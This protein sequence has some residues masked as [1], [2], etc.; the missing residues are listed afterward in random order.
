VTDAEANR[1]AAEAEY[2]LVQN[3]A[4]DSL[5]SVLTNPLIQGLK[6]EVSRLEVRHAY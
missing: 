5:P 6:Q 3:R 1:I 2:R 4:S